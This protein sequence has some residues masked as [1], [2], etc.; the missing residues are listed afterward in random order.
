MYPTFP[1]YTIL[2]H[3]H[4][5]L[6][7]LTANSLPWCTRVG[8]LIVCRL[9]TSSPI[10]NF[11]VRFC[12]GSTLVMVPVLSHSVQCLLSQDLPKP[13]QGTHG[14]SSTVW[15]WHFSVTFEFK[16]GHDPRKTGW[17]KIQWTCC[18]LS[19][20]WLPVLQYLAT[21]Q[22]PFSFDYG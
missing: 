10:W 5:I 6:I 19:Y 14:V 8:K 12:F 9:R 15:M 22:S 1:S 4:L 7:T 18:T 16:C 20:I 11:E 3:V 21:G 17:F 2:C 13:L